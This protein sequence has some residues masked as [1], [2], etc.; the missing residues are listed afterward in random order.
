ML[1]SVLVYGHTITP[2]QWFGVGMV[3]SG[4]G[5]EAELGRRDKVEKARIAKAKV[6]GF[7]GEK[8][9]EKNI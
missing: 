3:F 2:M 1:M 7:A 4:I 8:R 9:K 6:L 5:A